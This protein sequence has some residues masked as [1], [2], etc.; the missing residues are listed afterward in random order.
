MSASTAPDAAAPE[1]VAPREPVPTGA[2]APA[3]ESAD[4]GTTPPV[5]ETRH[6][7]RWVV[8]AAALILLAQ[9]V[10]GLA[11]NPGWD[12]PTFARYVT[13]N[14]VLSALRVTVELTIWGTALGFLLG[15]A[16]AVARL[17][18]GVGSGT[19]QLQL[20]VK[21]NEQNRADGLAPID[22]AYFQQVTD[23]YLALASQRLDGYLGPN[24]TAIYH[25]ATAKQTKIVGTFSGA[26]EALQGEIAVLTKKDNGLITAVQHALAYAPRAR[27]L[28][29]GDRPLGPA[30]RSGHRISNQSTRPA[31]EALSR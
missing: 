16:L 26:G 25:A 10:H 31:R 4:S 20:L 13:A 28:P 12:W 3:P 14:S 22:I 17:S 29:A 21:W 7:W 30:Q 6:P 19:N 11:T 24:P 5:A 18:N 23:Y 2:L 15:T 8:G 9:F 1:T 27:R